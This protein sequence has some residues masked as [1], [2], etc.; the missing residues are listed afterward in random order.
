MG[1]VPPCLSFPIGTQ[2]TVGRKARVGASPFPTASRYLWGAETGCPPHPALL[3]GAETGI[4]MNP[5]SIKM[6]KRVL[7][8]PCAK[9]PTEQ[10]ARGGPYCGG[11]PPPLPAEP[12]PSPPSSALVALHRP[13]GPRPKPLEG[14]GRSIAWR[15]HRTPPTVPV[16]CHPAV[17]CHAAVPCYPAVPC[18]PAMLQ[19]PSRNPTPIHQELGKSR[20]GCGSAFSPA[21]HGPS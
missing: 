21:Q 1:L 7:P 3:A 4:Q 2:G 19:S 9:P 10:A 5:F 13:G 18:H 8:F 14:A 20:R 6:C 11:A 15:C 17:P 16:P 12:T